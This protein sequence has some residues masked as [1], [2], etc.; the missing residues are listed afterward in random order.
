M[1]KIIKLISVDK[2]RQKYLKLF[3]VDSLEKLSLE[4]GNQFFIKIIQ[5]FKNGKLTLD[6]LSVFGHNIF[7]TIGKKYPKSD[8]FQASLFASELNFAVRSRAVFNNISM[9]LEEI[10]KFFIKYEN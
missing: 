10:E 9:Y 6:E 1:P 2:K 4:Q 3:N 5:D 7:H 8:L